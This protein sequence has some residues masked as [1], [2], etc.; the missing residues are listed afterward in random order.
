MTIVHVPPSAESVMRVKKKI[1]ARFKDRVEHA[2]NLLRS[3]AHAVLED[4]L[5]GNYANAMRGIEKL[6]EEGARDM[7]TYLKTEDIELELA[8]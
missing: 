4:L 6:G 5:V 1:D 2:P 7:R 3:V 8:A